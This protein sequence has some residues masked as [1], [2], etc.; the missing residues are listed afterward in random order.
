[1]KKNDDLKKQIAA[2]KIKTRKIEDLLPYAKNSRNHSDSQIAQIAAS[3][4]E[5][6]FTNPVLI[7]PNG[8]IIA[9]HGRVLAAMRLKLTEVP[10]IELSHLTD[11]QARAYVIADN[12]LALNATWNEEM[13]SLELA[14]LQSENFEIE[15]LGFSKEFLETLKTEEFEF[16]P[17]DKNSYV[18]KL[19]IK[20]NFDNEDEMQML[21]DELN[22]REYR[23]RRC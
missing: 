22:S 15:L 7:K 16:S 9:G 6:G 17:K 2:S 19:E 4:S 1:M 10:C 12:Q 14:D 3:I 11:T 8:E 21:F 20:I 13:L 23:V 5:F 18:E